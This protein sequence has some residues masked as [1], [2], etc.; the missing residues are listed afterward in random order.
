MFKGFFKIIILV[1]SVFMLGMVYYAVTAPEELPVI[2]SSEYEAE[3]FAIYTGDGDI[4][5]ADKIKEIKKS[6]F[7]GSTV[8]TDTLTIK[9]PV[10]IIENP[11]SASITDIKDIVL[12]LVDKDRKVLLIYIDGMGYG[13]YEKAANAGRLPYIAALGKGRKAMTVYPSITDVTFASMVTGE[14]PK[15]TG[16]H[17]RDKKPM[18]VETIFDIVSKKGK[19]SKVIEGNMKILTDEVETVL[20]I[21]ENKNGTIDDEIYACALQELQNPPDVLLVHF[22]SFDDKGHEYGPDSEEAM[23]QLSALDSFVEKLVADYTGEVIITADH[24]MHE[25]EGGGSHGAFLSS[26]MFIP[27]IMRK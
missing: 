27:I 20:N 21:D 26:D 2:N 3:S 7:G 22:H 9:K 14:T 16:I 18:P 4:I 6:L 11:P 25:Y 23:A 19:S 1:V 12:E 5:L 8:K 13:V 24:G 15:Y 17:N 10:G